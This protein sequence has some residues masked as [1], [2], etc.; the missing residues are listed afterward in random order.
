MQIVTCLCM[1]Y[2]HSAPN[3]QQKGGRRG[4][5]CNMQLQTDV[6]A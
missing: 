3:T 6:T 2:V 5:Y 1:T 4:L